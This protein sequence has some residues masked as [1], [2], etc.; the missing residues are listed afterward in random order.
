MTYYN[1]K[2]KPPVDHAGEALKAL[3]AMTSGTE[4]HRA[5]I[6][7]VFKGIVED[8]EKRDGM[9]VKDHRVVD[10]V[11]VSVVIGFPE[12]FAQYE[13]TL[14]VK[15][16]LVVIDTKNQ[17]F[18]SSF[19]AGADDGAEQLIQNWKTV[20]E[21]G[22]DWWLDQ[23]AS[24]VSYD[25]FITLNDTE[26]DQARFAVECIGEALDN[27]GA[28]LMGGVHRDAY[29]WVLN[30]VL[31]E[32]GITMENP[33][34]LVLT[35]FRGDHAAVIE[36]GD[37]E[38]I[39]TYFTDYIFGLY[40]KFESRKKEKAEAWAEYKA[41]QDKVNPYKPTPD[42]PLKGVRKDTIGQIDAYVGEL[43]K[44]RD[45]MIA[46]TDD[47]A[48]PEW[49][50]GYA[51]VRGHILVN[52]GR[53]VDEWGAEGVTSTGKQRVVDYLNN[54]IKYYD[55]QGAM[56]DSI[57]KSMG[58]FG[59]SGVQWV[60]NAGNVTSQIDIDPEDVV[61]PVLIKAGA[62]LNLSVEE[63]TAKLEAGEITRT[64]DNG[65]SEFMFNTGFGI[66]IPHEDAIT[67]D[68]ED[69]GESGSTPLPMD[70]S[71]IYFVA[72]DEP[73]MDGD[74]MVCSVMFAPKEFWDKNQ[75]FPDWHM[76]NELKRIGFDLSN[77]EEVSENAFYTLAKEFGGPGWNAKD[78]IAHL[79]AAGFTHKQDM[80][81]A[82]GG[83]DDPEEDPTSLDRFFKPAD[84]KPQE[85]T[86]D[87]VK[88][89]LVRHWPGSTDWKRVSKKKLGLDVTRVFTGKIGGKPLKVWVNSG[90]DTDTRNI[91]GWEIDDTMYYG[92]HD[93]DNT[94]TENPI[95][96]VSKSEWDR[97]NS[98]PD[99]EQG[100]ML[101]ALYNLPDEYD[102][103]MENEFSAEDKPLADI[104]S[105][106]QALGFVYNDQIKGY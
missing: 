52:A 17:Y 24:H 5:T 31:P 102:E 100:R 1:H 28:S 60:D 101:T 83:D 53:E 84:A 106:L 16:G 54:V 14:N 38:E 33:F 56:L 50:K 94:D 70:R 88:A 2:P 78:T 37:R 66:S 22:N 47:D 3:R 86:T 21:R 13:I 45:R 34:Q 69:E 44:T 18:P 55:Q 6:G 20:V 87:A 10:G 27:T 11:G 30:V 40:A 29:G 76:S 49:D 4:E 57:S 92:F 99:Q 19:D 95:C 39:V 23:M 65:H 36:R 79:T 32:R 71:Q 104:H 77:F 51:T 91:R 74:G 35:V 96:F 15:R 75:C 59:I 25:N 62:A 12:P 8:A 63:L 80:L 89:Y 58:A 68:D 61:D 81:S 85:V 90:T 73:D 98:V 7:S 41:Y 43:K 9:T 48:S 93:P 97:T 42:D 46:I 67:D 72:V 82:F 26:R 64:D 103:E 105:E